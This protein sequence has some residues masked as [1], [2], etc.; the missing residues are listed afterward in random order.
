MDENRYRYFVVYFYSIIA[1]I[2]GVVGESL[3]FVS[4]KS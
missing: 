4:D 1:W 3:E 2:N